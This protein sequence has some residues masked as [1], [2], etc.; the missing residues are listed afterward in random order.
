MKRIWPNKPLEKDEKVMCA[1]EKRKNNK[2]EDF[3]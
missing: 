2:S 3:K 1:A